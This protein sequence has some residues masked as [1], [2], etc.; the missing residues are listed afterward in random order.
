MKRVGPRSPNSEAFALRGA[1]PRQPTSK[2]RQNHWLLRG[3]EAGPQAGRMLG[4]EGQQLGGQMVSGGSGGP[5]GGRGKGIPSEGHSM[6]GFWPGP[7]SWL[8]DGHFLTV[9]SHNGRKGEQA[10]WSSG[11]HPTTS[12][13]LNHFLTPNAITLGVQFCRSVMSDSGPPCPSPTSGVHSN[14]CPSSR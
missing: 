10:S 7:T 9:F 2:G 1:G 13:N 11:F 5:E 6:V 14:S 4:S 8:A 3:S 12:F